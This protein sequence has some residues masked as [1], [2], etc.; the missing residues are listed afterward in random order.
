MYPAV[1][2]VRSVVL[3]LRS[4]HSW[5]AYVL[6]ISG[7]VFGMASCRR[8]RDGIRWA[9]PSTRSVQRHCKTNKKKA[10]QSEKCIL[11]HT[12]FLTPPPPPSPLLPPP[13][14]PRLRFIRDHKKETLGMHHSEITVNIF[15]SALSFSLV[16]SVGSISTRYLRK[17]P[18]SG[19]GNLL[20][21]KIKPER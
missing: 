13:T 6:R 18:S 14:N 1:E 8:L 19:V 9:I 10:K 17:I 3:T 2:C 20:P 4:R 11:K 15:L 12:L 21:L 7:D 16:F 5:H